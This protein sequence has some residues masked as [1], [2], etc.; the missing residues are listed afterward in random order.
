MFWKDRATPRRAIW[1]GTQP[2][3]VDDRAV[4]RREV[5]AAFLGTVEAAHRV[6]QTRLAGA[7]RSDDGEDLA[8]SHGESD[9]AQSL[10]STKGEAEAVD[11]QQGAAALWRGGL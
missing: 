9:V 8:F 10:D 3:Q 6:E 5:D 4:A 1:C 2:A 7:V 11:L